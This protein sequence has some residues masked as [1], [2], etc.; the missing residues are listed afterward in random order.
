MTKTKHDDPELREPEDNQEEEKEIDLLELVYKLWA[1]RKLILIWCMWGVIAGLVIAFSIPKEYTSTVKLAP[2]FKTSGSPKL[3]GGLSALASMAGINAAGNS[4]SDAMYPQLYPDIVGSVPF[5]TS[6]FE[7]PVTDKEGEHYTVREYLEEETSGPWWGF[8]LGLPGK[9]IGLFK[10]SEEVPEGH[11]L[12]NFQLTLDEYNLVEALSKRVTASVDQ[13]TSVITID[14]KMQDPLVAA[15]LVDTVVSRLR[16]HITEYRTDKSRQD[17]EYAQTL[18]NEAQK[19]YYEAQQRLADYVDK[20]HNLATRSASITRER[21]E[22]EAS[23]AFNLYN[24]TSLQVQNAK[25]KVQETTPVYTVI[26]P[27]TVAIKATSPR[28]GLILA[29][30]VF[31]S[32]VACAAWILFGSPMVDEYKKKVSEIKAAEDSQEAKPDSKD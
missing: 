2:E 31:L 3:S 27:A 29:G 14:A 26:T 19:E 9:I 16:D 23:L 22:N 11:Q 17:L 28:K 1:Q 13:K 20:N 5:L 32:F 15:V 25:S 7:V 10:T 8:I 21:L 30:F 4:G 18:N 6:L 24:E 12:D